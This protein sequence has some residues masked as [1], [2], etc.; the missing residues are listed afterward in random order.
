MTRAHVPVPGARRKEPVP[1]AAYSKHVVTRRGEGVL[2]FIQRWERPCN[3][4]R[5]ALTGREYS[6]RI[7]HF[8][9]LEGLSSGREA[10]RNFTEGRCTPALQRARHETTRRGATYE[11]GDIRVLQLLSGSCVDWT[12][13][14]EKKIQIKS[15]SNKN[16]KK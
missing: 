16:R 2:F 4:F 13:I 10:L 9:A 5:G 11:T 12:K 14:Y 6:S 1:A 3:Y 8:S 15:R 7:T